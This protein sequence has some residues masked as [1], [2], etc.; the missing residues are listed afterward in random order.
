MSKGFKPKSEPH[1]LVLMKILE[2]DLFGRPMTMRVLYDE[3]TTKLNGGEEFATVWM[4]S[5]H[6]QKEDKGL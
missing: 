4:P 1:R 5:V 2:R 6:F 3:E